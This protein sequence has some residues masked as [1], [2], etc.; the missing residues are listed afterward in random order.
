MSEETVTKPR[1]RRDESGTQC[2]H[3][4]IGVMRLLASSPREGL[5][6][7]DIASMLDLSHPTA[8]RILKALEEEGVVERVQGSRRYTVGTEAAWLGLAANERF[9]ITSV[10]APVLDGLSASI[11]DTVFLAVPSINDSV[12]ADRRTGS[13]PVQVTT[14]AVGARRPLGISVAGRAMMA[15]MGDR[16]IE[17]V[18]AQNSA[19]Y[20]PYRMTAET[21]SASVREARNAGYLWADSVTAKDRRALSVPVL[22]MAGN[23]VAALSVIAPIHRL[24]EGR[25]PSIVP[26]LKQAAAEISQ[27]LVK[28]SIAA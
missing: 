2:I 18:L 11:K 13:Y 24:P 20:E 26:I 16:K 28:R 14:L 27:S 3:R 21:V 23:P 25:I 8:H 6:L 10:A 15:F 4:S 17:A 1:A 22:N 7:V 12:Y 5:K 9:P 19:R